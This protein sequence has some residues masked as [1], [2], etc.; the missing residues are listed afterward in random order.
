MRGGAEEHLLLVGAPLQE[1][2]LH[3][4]LQVVGR[5]RA[6]CVKASSIRRVTPSAMSPGTRHSDLRTS[7]PLP[8]TS[9]R[10]LSLP[11]NGVATVIVA[12]RVSSSSNEREIAGDERERRR[13]G[14]VVLIG[15][16]RRLA[17]PGLVDGDAAARDGHHLAAILRLCGSRGALSPPAIHVTSARARAGFSTKG[18]WPRMRGIASVSYQADRRI[19]RR[20][21][22]GRGA[23]GAGAADRRGSLLGAVAAAAFEADD[24]ARRRVAEVDGRAGAHRRRAAKRRLDGA[25]R[26]GEEGEGAGAG[27]SQPIGAGSV[28]VGGALPH[29][30]RGLRNHRGSHD[31]RGHGAPQVRWAA[32]PR[33]EPGRRRAEA[34]RIGQSHLTR[35]QARRSAEA[36]RVRHARH[37]RQAR[38]ARHA[39][40]RRPR[41]RDPGGGGDL[42]QRRHARSIAG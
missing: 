13:E 9:L 6:A 31:R 33:R 20:R 3:A 30:H 17:E 5:R 18:L 25:P 2:L 10:R 23:R 40:Q 15:R 37:A 38:Q 16:R 36:R 12:R 1:D 14:A 21:S 8:T 29:G 39:R 24:A 11:T 35:D 19:A 22:R 42:G 28:A 26:P 32:G 4:V 7:I 34:G 41:R 27:R